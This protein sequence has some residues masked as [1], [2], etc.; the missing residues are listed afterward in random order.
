MTVW[1]EVPIISSWTQHPDRYKFT[2]L[3]LLYDNNVNLVARETYGLLEFMGD[4]GGLF[5][6]L[7]YIFRFILSPLTS[8]VLAAELMTSLF[9]VQNKS[10]SRTKS[11]NFVEMFQNE[12]MN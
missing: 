10:N 3:E 12:F 2:G 5:E 7:Y 8:F 4:L 11:L 6:A 1:Q 9:R